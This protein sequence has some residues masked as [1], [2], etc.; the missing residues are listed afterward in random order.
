MTMPAGHIRPAIRPQ[1]ADFS[2]EAARTKSDR[3]DVTLATAL[4]AVRRDEPL[5]LVRAS[6]TERTIAPA[7]AGGSFD[8]YQ[9]DTVEAAA[10]AQIASTARAMPPRLDQLCTICG[11][12]RSVATANG[13]AP[14]LIVGFLGL[15]G[16][17]DSVVSHSL[18]W[19]SWYAFLPWE[20][21]RNA[22][23]P[24]EFG[25]FEAKL[26]E[27]A[28]LLEAQAMSR[29]NGAGIDRRR[30]IESLFGLKGHAWD[31]TKA[32]E[33][34]ELLQALGLISE[35]PAQQ[36]GQLQADAN[37]VA[38]GARPPEG[39]GIAMSAGHRHILAAA[40]SR[41]RA[42]VKEYPVV[43]ELFAGEFTLFELQK[44]VEAILKPNLHKQNFRRQVESA[45]LVESTGKQKRDT[46]G[47]PA[48]LYRYSSDALLKAL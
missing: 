11:H 8:A 7:L 10:R 38:A 31:E 24:G 28:E 4:V 16:N 2:S 17:P 45:N 46:G 30:Q 19:Q 36:G 33:R 20:D 40:V 1:N 26:I 43:P 25:P 39:M 37:G 29:G 5:I 47:R 41:L 3:V 15:F 14:S 18:S 42:R 22:A 6:E 12:G 23:S 34:F 13:F 35:H 32:L 9:Y 21:R 48:E 44:I 27:R